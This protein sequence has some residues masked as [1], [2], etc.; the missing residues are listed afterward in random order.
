MVK[1][2]S[3]PIRNWILW[4]WHRSA[5]AKWL[6]KQETERN[7]ENYELRKLSKWWNGFGSNSFF[8]GHC[9]PENS[10]FLVDDWPKSRNPLTTPETKAKVTR[11]FFSSTFN[12]I[13]VENWMKK[14]KKCR[15]SSE[16]MQKIQKNVSD[17]VPCC[18]PLSLSLFL[19]I[20]HPILHLVSFH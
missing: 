1:I 3:N 6:T 17:N 9:P 7:E 16:T 19:S 10:L 4:N 18:L 14:R 8:P 5:K 13:P 12:F 2:F 11:N 20:N 15:N